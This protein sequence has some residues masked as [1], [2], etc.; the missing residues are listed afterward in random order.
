MADS[1]LKSERDSKAEKK[2]KGHKSKSRSSKEV[3]DEYEGEFNAKGKRE[4][5]GIMRFSEGDVY[6]GQWKAG[7]MEGRGTYKMADGDVYEGLYKAGLKE[8]PGTYWYSSGRA[9]VAKYTAGSD[10]GEGARWD[11]DRQTAWRLLNGEVVDEISVEEAAQIAE[12]LG[13]PVPPQ[14][15]ANSPTTSPLLRDTGAM[16]PPPTAAAAEPAPPCAP[17]AAAAAAPVDS[18]TPPQKALAPLDE[19]AVVPASPELS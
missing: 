9:D 10:T 16:V 14:V 18:K 1:G 6:E 5:K 11:V 3:T 12:R 8:G 15:S 13:E 19:V 7:K 17:P 2:S 4:G